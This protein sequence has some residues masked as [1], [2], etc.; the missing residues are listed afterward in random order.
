[1]ARG[2]CERG[3][4]SPGPSAVAGQLPEAAVVDAEMV[5]DLVI[6]GLGD[7]RGEGLARGVRAD[8]RP[9]KDR[10]LARN[11]SAVGPE[12]RPRNALV[13]AVQPGCARLLQL[14]RARLVLDDDRDAGE[15]H[16]EGLRK[17]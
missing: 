11:R 8:E 16:L 17:P 4:V 2:K 5:G 12:S 3:T 13:Q 14:P 10:D 1:M 7:G 6:D 9:G 15:R